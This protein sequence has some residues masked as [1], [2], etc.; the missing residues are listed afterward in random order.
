MLGTIFLFD[1]KNVS[2]N[3]LVLT[4]DMSK[5]MV[6][7]DNT[8][9]LIHEEKAQF[10][11]T[12]LS[13]N[14][15][16]Y[17]IFRIY[18]TDYNTYSIYLH[19][20]QLKDVTSLEVYSYVYWYSNILTHNENGYWSVNCEIGKQGVGNILIY[21]R[22]ND[23]NDSSITST[24]TLLDLDYNAWYDSG[25]AN[26]NLGNIGY[27]VNKV[28]LSSYLSPILNCYEFYYSDYLYNWYSKGSSQVAYNDGY[29]SGIKNGY[30]TGYDQGYDVGVQAGKTAAQNSA[31]LSLV[32][33]IPNIFAAVWGFII[34]IMQ[35]SVL[36]ISIFD[37]FLL[38][39]CVSLIILIFR[40]I[41]L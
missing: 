32:S 29:Q 39:C 28:Y 14:N 20:F 12:T 3:S 17:I 21:S 25:T 41:K 16:Q 10:V 5:L 7:P 30:Q 23:F 19:L 33:F 38:V 24:N 1:K 9:Y 37:L 2:A 15:V 6:A 11:V 13:E 31:N 8:N 34:Y 26:L 22:Y 27:K 40:F 36:G 4:S 18:M 35:F